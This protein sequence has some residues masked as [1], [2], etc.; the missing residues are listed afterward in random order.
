MTDDDCM[1]WTVQLLLLQALC[2]IHWTATS[3]VAPTHVSFS[4]AA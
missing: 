3:S 2:Y 4:L 1:A